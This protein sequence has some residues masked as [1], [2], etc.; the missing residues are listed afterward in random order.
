MIPPEMGKA[1]FSIAAWIVIASGI[2]LLLVERG[3][4]EAYVA[5]FSLLVGLLFIGVIWLAI[6][7]W[8]S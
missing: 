4:A 7:R 8:N 3:T 6:R 1:A 5:L 2:A